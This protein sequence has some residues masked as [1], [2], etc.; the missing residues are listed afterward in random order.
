MVKWWLVVGGGGSGGDGW[1]GYQDLRAHWGRN[2]NI[3]LG[4]AGVREFA[5]GFRALLTAMC[6]IL[7]QGWR[8]GGRSVAPQNLNVKAQKFEPTSNTNI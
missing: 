6:Y 1:P 8:L 4:L 7:D 5:P 3:T 2:L